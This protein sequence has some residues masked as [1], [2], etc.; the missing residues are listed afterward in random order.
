MKK[1]LIIGHRGAAG[2][3]LE[4]TATSIERALNY[5]LYAVEIDVRITADGKLVLCHD[6]D[7][8]RIANDPRKVADLTLKQAQS[9]PLVDGSRLLS[10]SQALKII[11]STPVI[12][13]LKDSGSAHALLRTLVKFPGANV[14]IGSFKLDELMLVRSLDPS[15]KLYILEHT[16]PLE[17]MQIAGL[18]KLDGVGLNYWLINPLTYW[19]ARRRK[20]AVYVYTVNNKF[21]VRFLSW[22]YP[23]V[24]ICTDHPEWFTKRRR[25]KRPNKK[26]RLRA[27]HIRS[28]R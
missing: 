8:M 26:G 13:E 19:H 22:L 15:I 4:N 21:H 28:R 5:D 12:I 24:L 11:G 1:R 10:L 25:S 27:R 6:P 16:K 23:H 9:V 14:V 18:L 20:L 2:L 17:T 7:L 3:E